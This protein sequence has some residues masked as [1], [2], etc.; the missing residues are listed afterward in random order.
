M[1]NLWKLQMKAIKSRFEFFVENND[2]ISALKT[3][4]NAESFLAEHI[5]GSSSFFQ[6]KAAK[7]LRKKYAPKMLKKLI[8]KGWIDIDKKD[9]DVMPLSVI[10]EYVDKELEEESAPTSQD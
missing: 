2:K 10:L 1:A 5:E 6:R 8:K 9:L 3:Y 7:S 4:K